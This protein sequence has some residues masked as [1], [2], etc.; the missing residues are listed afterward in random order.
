M[1]TLPQPPPRRTRVKMCG[2][3]RLEDAQAAVRFGVDALGFIFTR[4]SPR[5]ISPE[6]AAA[7]IAE[8]PPFI[9][10]V[11]VFVDAPLV[12]VVQVAERNFSLLQLHGNESPEY[13]LKVREAMPG[14]GII[15]AFRVGPS[16]TGEDF[17]PYASCVDAFLLDTYVK[18]SSGGT[19]LVFD[20]SVI[21]TL[22]IVR[23]I[24]LAGGISPE[25]V[26]QAIAE[27]QPYA[28]DVNS[29][30]ERQPGVKDHERLRWLMQEVAETTCR[31][32]KKNHA[33]VTSL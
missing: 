32:M 5:H 4:K 14:C 28:V 26:G 23:P 33:V 17:A 15:K 16:S 29:A 20:W 10:R 1:A 3:T 9:D 13:C 24:I 2:T 22:N 6:H 19:G 18:G 7:I 8:L 27:I 12:E 21:E 11:G 30:V 31:Y 25:N